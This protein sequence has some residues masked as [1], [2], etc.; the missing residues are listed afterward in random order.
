MAMSM[1]ASA[2]PISASAAARTTGWGAAPANHR[3]APSTVAAATTTGRLPTVPTRRPAT[4]LA[5]MAPPANPTSTSP[6]PA[7]D[8]PR[9]AWRSGRRGRK[10]GPPRPLATK[11]TATA[12]AV[13][14]T[15]RRSPAPARERA[16][17]RHR[18]RDREE[19]ERPAGEGVEAPQVLDDRDAGGQ[20]GR[21][22]RPLPG[23]GPVDVDRV[24]ADDGRAGGHQRLGGV[25]AQVRMALG[26]PVGA[27]APVPVPARVH[28][29][30]PARQVEPG[31]GRGADLLAGGAVDQDPG[32]VGDPAGSSPARSWPS[33]KRWKGVSR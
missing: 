12:R 17:A 5:T 10:L 29:H 27:A 16:H 23:A 28:E 7:S 2:A 19:P 26:V 20:Q 24:D 3:L 25:D 1:A 33:A 22:D 14:L 6:R 4:G 32:H 18:G 31:Q 9:S 15:R 11:A 30:G 21:V 8:R 13:G